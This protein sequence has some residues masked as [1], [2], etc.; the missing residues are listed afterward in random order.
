MYRHLELAYLGIQVPEPTSLSPFFGEVIGLVPG[1]AVAPDTLTW[2]DDDK[3]HRL[4][5]EAGDAND[6]TFV[7]F[8]AV[9]DA[10]FDATVDRIAAAGG[11]LV[12]GTAGEC[13]DRRVERLVS[14]EAP[15]GV[16]VEIVDRAG[17]RRRR[18]S[19]PS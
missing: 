1:D 18:R 2:R 5:V 11:E 8:E 19:S 15:W 16:R 3:V 13:A 4:I 10:A 7:G 14:T 17:R 6:A 12:V 9:D